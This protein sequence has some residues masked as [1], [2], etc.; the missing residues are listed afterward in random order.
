MNE[1]LPALPAL[2]A[3]LAYLIFYTGYRM[4]RSNVVE[5]L[6]A[7]D[8][9]LLSEERRRE[10]RKERSLLQR[11]GT[12]LV[13]LLRR[14]I[15]HRGIRYLTS[16]VHRAG[17]PQGITVDTILRTMGGYLLVT[18]PLSLLLTSMNLWYIAPLLLLMAV[19][20]PISRLAGLSNRRRERIDADLPDFLD[21]L[22]V[23]VTA[24]IAFRPALRRVSARFHGP[25]AD[26]VNLALDNLLHG[27]SV[28]DAF[29]QMRDRSSS[30]MMRRFVRAFLQAEEL[31]APLAE[32]LNQIALDMRRDNAQRLRQKAARA[33]P[34]VSLVGSIV[35]VPAAIILILAGVW[36]GIDL[37]IDLGGLDLG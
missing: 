19:V 5:G 4:L 21:I 17:R 18:I 28:R 2:G 3:L 36:F 31:G 23:T 22:A 26:D 35:L 12:P 34:Q 15:G 13:P 30:Q 9:R 25:L 10:A 7:G 16:L 8:L 1:M 33:V 27:A 29:E 24:G 6:D 11:V 32:T 37:D 14:A 20:M